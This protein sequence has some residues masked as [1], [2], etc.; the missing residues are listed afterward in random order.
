VRALGPA[1]DPGQLRWLDADHLAYV[2]GGAV[3]VVDVVR[4]AETLRIAG[5][6][7]VTLDGWIAR[8][9]CAR[10][11][12]EP[13]F[14]VDPDEPDADADSDADDPG[15]PP[16][17]AEPPARAPAPAA[18]PAGGRDAGVSDRAAPADARR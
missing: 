4:G 3:R 16:E 9:G 8:R 2:T 10:G 12:G 13:V 6:A 17:L 14:A 18:P 15:A 11:D 1:D 7:G 5:G